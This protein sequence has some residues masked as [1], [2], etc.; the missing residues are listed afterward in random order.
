[1]VKKAKKLKTPKKLPPGEYSGCVVD[2]NANASNP[3][4]R[5]I[6]GPTVKSF[7]RL[8]YSDQMAEVN[9][10]IRSEAL[11]ATGVVPLKTKADMMRRIAYLES[12]IDVNNSNHE[13][14]LNTL[15]LE[16]SKEISTI[17]RRFAEGLLEAHMSGRRA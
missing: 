1:M 4:F 9:V 5:I 2:Y 6:P 17:Y 8:P 7:R 12:R 14:A 10:G 16:T 3:T 13:K 15:R 11:Q